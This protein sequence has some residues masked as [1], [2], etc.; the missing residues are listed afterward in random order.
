MLVHPTAELLH[1]IIDTKTFVICGWNVEFKTTDELL[2]VGKKDPVK[3]HDF[4]DS[5]DRKIRWQNENPGCRLR[6]GKEF[7]PATSCSKSSSSHRTV[8]KPQKW[9]VPIK[10][11]IH[12]KGRQPAADELGSETSD[13]KVIHGVTPPS[14]VVSF[15]YVCWFVHVPMRTP[16]CVCGHLR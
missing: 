5:A 7:R 10:D 2:N 16:V 4:L 6:D 12:E 1:L 14:V 8:A 9:L 11:F 3:N 13:G 15:M